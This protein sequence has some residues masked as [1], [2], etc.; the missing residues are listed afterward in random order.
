LLCAVLDAAE[1]GSETAAFC[2]EIS[3]S[4]MADRR[5][6]TGS[7]PSIEEMLY[8]KAERQLP[9]LQLP[10]VNALHVGRSGYLSHRPKAFV[11]GLALMERQAP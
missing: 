10:V 3:A 6:E 1:I 7:A 5:A 8:A 4:R 9:A 2:S 11:I